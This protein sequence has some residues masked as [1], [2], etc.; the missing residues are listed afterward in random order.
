MERK[1]F[2]L[3]IFASV[4][5][6]Y[7]CSDE[8][9]SSSIALQPCDSEG[10]V[11]C[12][13]NGG[14][15]TCENGY[16]SPSTCG[17]NK[18]C[19]EG[20][21]VSVC[22]PDSF[23]LKCSDELS[24]FV[25]KN[26][27]VDTEK[28][29]DGNI[30]HQGYCRDKSLTRCDN[31]YEQQCLDETTWAQCMVGYVVTHKCEAGSYCNRGMCAKTEPCD[32][33]SF[34][35]SCKS[36]NSRITC[37]NGATK[38]ENCAVGTMCLNG[39]CTSNCEGEVHMCS[40]DGM[41]SYSCE[42]G[43]LTPTIC[44]GSAVCKNGECE[45]MVQCSPQ[46][47]SPKCVDGKVER[48][49]SSFEI[50]QEECTSGKECF[51]GACVWD[52][53][54]SPSET[55]PVCLS[56]NSV[57][58]CLNSGRKNV[59]SCADGET[60][61]NGVCQK[62]DEPCLGD[63]KEC[64]SASVERSCVNGFW[65]SKV[66]DVASEVCSSGSCGSK[67]DAVKCESIGDAICVGNSIQVCENG[68]VSTYACKDNQHCES[69]IC[70]D[71]IKVGDPCDAALFVQQCLEDGKIA[72]CEDGIVVSAGC[73]EGMCKAGACVDKSCDAAL[74]TSECRGDFDITACEN[75]AVIKK[76]CGDNMHCSN[77]QCVP[78]ASEG[79]PCNPDSFVV[80][81][82][83]EG[84][85]VSCVKDEQSGTSS[86]HVS[87]CTG[88]T[89]FCMK[90]VCVACD[91]ATYGT[92]C[93]NGHQYTCDANGA[94]VDSLC[95][96]DYVCFDN[97]CA[98][99]DPSLNEKTCKDDST[100]RICNAQ[101]NFED[102]AC[103]AGFSCVQGE[104]TNSCTADSDC[105][106]SDSHY[107]CDNNQCKFKADCALTDP[108]VC[109]ENKIRSCKAP[110]IF[111]D[112]ACAAGEICKMNA[113]N[114]PE[115]R[116]NECD[117]DN[118]GIQCSDDNKKVTYCD[119]G[120]I[121][122]QMTCTGTDV[123]I[124][125]KCMGNECNPDVDPVSCKSDGKTQIYCSNGYIRD[126]QICPGICLNGACVDCDHN[127]T[128]DSCYGESY[129]VSCIENNTYMRISC[130]ADFKC[131]EGK[132]CISKCGEGFVES[133]KAD[134]KREWCDNGTIK[135]E[136]CDYRSD[137]RQGKCV[138]RDGAACT[139]N[140]YPERC[141][142]NGGVPVLEVCNAGTRTVQFQT[143]S[144][145]GTFCGTLEGLTQC[146]H[147]CSAGDSST[148]CSEWNGV[149]SV[150]KCVAGTDY[151]GNL[152]Y[153]VTRKPAIC[154]DGNS[155]S[156]R[157][158]SHNHYVFDYLPCNKMGSSC[159][160]TSGSCGFASCSAKSASCSGN[161]AINCQND[162]AANY[163][164]GGLV[165]TSMDCASV[166]GTCAVLNIDG[167]ER[168]LCNAS[169]SGFNGGTLTVSSLG[170]CLGNSLYVLIWTDSGVMA[171]IT[172]CST[173]CR[174]AT[175]QYNNQSVSYSYCE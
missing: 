100:Q 63:A 40:L 58:V 170:T 125:G 130:D 154:M 135:T 169:Q 147:S 73:G 145:A 155:M 28:C 2:I 13:Q 64:V 122:E 141:H 139:P 114:V 68:Y 115:C 30:C 116:G 5:L 34:K 32:S 101:G 146:Y 161:V 148:Y 7:G 99:C 38:V 166:N 164:L 165:Q 171:R 75:G 60:C 152:Q 4:A 57:Q 77:N 43:T 119:K 50:V 94:L 37:E 29:E 95:P 33:S 173:A 156:C 45:D 113:S 3:S 158:S 51:A 131:A 14:L 49:S 39:E 127:N 25:C 24:R 102:V 121:K 53:P 140:N 12:S 20:E 61:E 85:A 138:P 90:G 23:P 62:M 134:G 17:E 96:T 124:K 65:H 92:T 109:F 56:N 48:C 80:S 82:N 123:C 15:L 74:F 83:N 52:G 16:Y 55:T 9:Y 128:P 172:S 149:R 69:G 150:G 71:N 18:M 93:S 159:Q 19:V 117:P 175:T 76:S 129:K 105:Q 160:G 27:I 86:V 98:Q 167:V 112:V 174:T 8:S 91:P 136:D 35:N 44:S 151:K 137:C 72:I 104:C 36:I 47:F 162:P 10:E 133:C 22:S 89:P 67:A 1:L 168:A 106:K 81:C 78:D 59:Q 157:T 54:C 144:G 118:Y 143:C 108:A 132:G 6:L 163:G 46:T 41:M 84:K 79:D 110:G 26:G 107:Y 88:D 11:I 31:S 21:C 42:N 70:F 111:D 87:E 142:D 153:G 103:I 66:C 120:Y 126:G 97:H